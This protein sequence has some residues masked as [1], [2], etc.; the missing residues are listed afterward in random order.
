M[1]RLHINGSRLASSFIQR[2]AARLL[3]DLFTPL[4]PEGLRWLVGHNAPISDVL[5]ISDAQR[6]LPAAVVLKLL[7]EH[8]PRLKQLSAVRQAEFTA[9]ARQFRKWAGVL[10]DEDLYKLL[11]AWAREALDG[12]KAGHRWWKAQVKQ[13]RQAIGGE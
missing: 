1:A 2:K 6:E 8:Y 5:I 12:N 9:Q 13:L 10:A 4:G 3:A 11:P 7:N